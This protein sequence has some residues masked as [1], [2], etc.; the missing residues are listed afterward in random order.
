MNP[1]TEILAS[2]V[3]AAGT[4]IGGGFATAIY[5]DNEE[6][7][8]IITAGKEGELVGAL[9]TRGENIVGARS[10]TDG[11]ANTIAYA[12]AGSEF[13]QRVLELR[14]GG[15]DDWAIPAF[16]QQEPQYRVFKPTTKP[17]YCGWRDGE[18][19]AAIPATLPYTEDSPS[20]TT[21][22]AFKA[23]G[24]E[25]FEPGWYLSSTQYSPVYAYGQDFAVGHQGIGRKDGEARVRPVRRMK[26]IHSAIQ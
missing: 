3:P 9:G 24:A 8:L 19:A 26:I 13:A 17:N 5:R 20:Q 15:F 7:Y 16:Y 10:F 22:E 23:G 12:E 14:I 2:D 25:A 18:N 11:L 21:I 6:G 1:K 4:P